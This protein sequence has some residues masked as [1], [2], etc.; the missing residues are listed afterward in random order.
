[1]SSQRA[2]LSA[3]VS[4]A[5]FQ[6]FWMCSPPGDN[7]DSR[8]RPWAEGGHRAWRG[9]GRRHADASPALHDLA[10]LTDALVARPDVVR[11][12]HALRVGRAGAVV[13]TG[14]WK[15]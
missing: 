4:I 5:S 2:P 12:V 8:L 13:E 7:V 6:V 10:E 11:G 9:R 1:M 14:A 3:G 15:R